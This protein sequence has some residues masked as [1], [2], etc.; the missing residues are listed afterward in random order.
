MQVMGKLYPKHSNVAALVDQVALLQ[1]NL[2]YC[3][4]SLVAQKDVKFAYELAQD[5]IVSQAREPVQKN[6]GKKI[7]ETCA[8]CLE[9]VNTNRMF[10]I[11]GCLHRYCFSCMRRHV[12]VKLL[13]GM[14]PR[15]PHEKCMS[16]L[17]TDDCKNFLM[18]ELFDIL[19]QHIMETSIPP[20][21]K[22]YCPYRTCSALLSTTWYE[23]AGMTT[24]RIMCKKCHRPFCMNCKVPWHDDMTCSVYKQ[25]NPYPCAEDAKLKSL[26]TRQLWRQCGECKHMVSLSEGC[27]HI[28]CRYVFLSPPFQLF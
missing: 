21:K 9:D 13:Q 25:Q 12:E 15:C 24:E 28:Y 2:T 5:A 11:E 16:E 26:V 20:A 4:L 7:I 19:C 22:V 3:N 18:P 23:S 27:N 6:C 1:R 14:L 10:S 17:K 8:I